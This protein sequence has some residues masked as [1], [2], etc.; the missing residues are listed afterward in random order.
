LLVLSSPSFQPNYTIRQVLKHHPIAIS[1]DFFFI[2]N[3]S[4]ILPPLITNVYKN[5]DYLLPH[6][7]IIMQLLSDI[8]ANWRRPRPQ[9]PKP[10]PQP[11]PEPRPHQQLFD[12]LNV[13]LKWIP[14]V[15]CCTCSAVV[16][17]LQ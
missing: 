7:L 9:N 17:Q 14:F 11:L 6:L 15:S 13:K 12:R 8:F 3:V 5:L 4:C 10:R 16:T 2:G 1:G